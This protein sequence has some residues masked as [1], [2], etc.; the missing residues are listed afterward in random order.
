MGV[1]TINKDSRIMAI[2][3]ALGLIVGLAPWSSGS[4][5][6]FTPVEAVDADSG[7]KHSIAWVWHF[8]RKARK[9]PVVKFA[10]GALLG[11]WL[12]MGITYGVTKMINGLCPSSK[13]VEPSTQPLPRSLSS[14]RSNHQLNHCLLL[15]PSKS[16]LKLK[17]QHNHCLLILPRRR[18]SSTSQSKLSGS[19]PAMMGAIEPL[20]DRPA[21]S[22]RM[23]VDT[24]NKDSRIMAI[25]RA[26][27][28][29]V[30]LA[31]WSSGSS[32][33]FTP[34]HIEVALGSKRGHE[35]QPPGSRG[36]GCEQGEATKPRQMGI[37][38]VAISIALLGFGTLS[39]SEESAGGEFAT[40]PLLGDW[41]DCWACTM[42]FGELVSVYS[43]YDIEV[44]RIQREDMNR[45]VGAEERDVSKEK[46]LSPWQMVGASALTSEV[47]V[48]VALL[49]ATFINDY[50]LR[51][52][53]L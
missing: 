7:S 4:S 36:E 47:G 21:V 22:L 50:K 12:A 42:V 11:D 9:V 38:I 32:Y 40:G 31:P 26:L 41:A 2:S 5:Y 24:I 33:R 18:S 51:S 52:D 28:L 43:R 8:E 37:L 19:G 35:M 44:A 14:K 23:G 20:R 49:V 3:R 10:S 16:T 53:D 48:L 13:G 15:L 34:Y 39:A 45:T 46:L 30:G 6:Q 25:S 1:D 17:H 27:G 29:I